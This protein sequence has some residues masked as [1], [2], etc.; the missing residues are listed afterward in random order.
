[1]D[2]VI[3]SDHRGDREYLFKDIGVHKEDIKL[4]LLRHAL[5]MAET[6]SAS[7]A[8]EPALVSIA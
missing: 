6:A 2:I 7:K 8:I 4:K 1:M 3:D 5:I